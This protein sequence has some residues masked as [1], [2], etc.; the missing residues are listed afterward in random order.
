MRHYEMMLILS[1]DLD[2]DAAHALIER[3]ESQ[4]TGAGGQILKTDYWGKRQLAY[5]IDHHHHGYYAVIDFEMDPD[6]LLEIKRQLK[7]NDNVLRFKT[8]RPDIR[9]RKPSTPRVRA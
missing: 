3:V 1:D 7:I 6:P 4:I 2:D 5:E 8:L 9:V